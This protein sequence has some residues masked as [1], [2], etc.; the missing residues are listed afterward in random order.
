MYLSAERLALANQTVKETFEQ[1]SVAWQAIPHWDTRDP[2]QT[3]VPNDNVKN[4]QILS[5]TPPITV[6]AFNVTLAEAIAPTPDAVLA[7]VIINAVA[8]AAKVDD[9]VFTALRTGANT[10]QI[11]GSAT[12]QE[13]LDALIAARA[14]VENSGYRAPSCLVT[15]T[16]G[17][18]ELTKLTT[19]GFP[20]TDVLLPPANINSL[21]RAGALENPV[22]SKKFVLAYLLGRRQRIAPGDAMDASPGEEA[23]DLAVSIPPSLEVVGEALP[24]SPNSIQLVVKIGFALRVKDL[25]GYV[26]ILNP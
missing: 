24:L 21:Q 3:Q 14:D 16:K 4:P 26:A 20:G 13:I 22:P 23:L 12:T 5:L 9:A 17:L 25:S 6:P 8:L 2:S 15:N 19:S 7:T 1:C 10:E 18:Q 11:K